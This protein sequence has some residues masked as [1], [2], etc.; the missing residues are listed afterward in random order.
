MPGDG[1]ARRGTRSGRTSRSS[2]RL[3]LYG[4]SFRGP[5]SKAHQ[6]VL[7]RSSTQAKKIEKGST[8]RTAVGGGEGGREV[9]QAWRSLGSRESPAASDLPQRLRLPRAP[10]PGAHG[11]AVCA[12]R[13]YARGRRTLH[14]RLAAGVLLL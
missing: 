1:R 11:A 6:M 3:P 12:A 13:S 7:R 9:E 10:A 2:R 4:S 5:W 8:R 14:S